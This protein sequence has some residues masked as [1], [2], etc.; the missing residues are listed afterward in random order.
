MALKSFASL[1][2]HGLAERPLSKDY[3]ALADFEQQLTW[4]R[5]QGY[6]IDSFSGLRKRIE[7]KAW[8]DR[9]LVMSFDDG[10]VSN[11]R[12]AERLAE[13]GAAATFFIVKNSCEGSQRNVLR[14]AQVR[15]LAAAQDIGSHSVSHLR[16][17]RLSAPQLR[18]ELAD[19]KAWLED[20]C[21]KPVTAFSAPM[22]DYDR[23]AVR[24]ALELGY[25][26]FATSA[27][28]WNRPDTVARSRVVARTSVE[29]HA[30]TVWLSRIVTCRPQP[31]LWRR[32]RHL[33]AAP[34]KRVLPRKAL[35]RI[36]K[37]VWR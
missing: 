25:R 13:A 6:V 12:A 37:L 16:L 24:M 28:W 5:S 32:S 21:G 23:R 19:S 11:L 29:R 30:K 36:R 4:L 31:F 7:S 15:E 34:I 2:Y 14:P 1:L 3:V 33:L 9:Y 8:P 10:H 35:I 20:L 27:C 17:S 18:R 26:F 22:G